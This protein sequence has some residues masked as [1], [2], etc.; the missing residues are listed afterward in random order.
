MCSSDLGGLSYTPR[1]IFPVSRLA[2]TYDIVNA[3]P[4]HRYVVG[5]CLVHNCG[6]QG[7]VGAFI[8]MGAGYGLRPQALAKA[9]KSVTTEEDWRGYEDRYKL[10]EDTMGLRRDEFVAVSIIVSKWRLAHA[11]ITKSWWDYQDAAINAI[12]NPNL[13][14]QVGEGAIPVSYLSTGHFLF[15]MLPSG[16]CLSYAMPYLKSKDVTRV[17][18]KG[19]EYTRME[20]T[21]HFWGVSSNTKQWQALSLYGGLLCENNVQAVSRDITAWA[22]HNVEDA[23]LPVV[24]TVHDELLSEVRLGKDYVTAYE[25]LMSMVPKWAVRLPI[26]VKAWQHRRYVK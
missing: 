20:T 1:V 8:S 21:A 3:G 18:R 24:L 16:R 13:V 7:S 2:R 14:V 10:V 11:N 25:K 12:A 23:G 22:M 19:E 4:N 15:C 5:G 9:V 17:N 26:S 6:Y